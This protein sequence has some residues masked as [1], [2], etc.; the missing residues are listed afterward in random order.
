MGSTLQWRD[1]M[2]ISPSTALLAKCVCS[3]SNFPAHAVY[4]RS[5][6]HSLATD[7][8][9]RRVDNVQPL[10]APMTPINTGRMEAA[11]RDPDANNPLAPVS[12]FGAEFG[13]SSGSTLILLSLSLSLDYSPYCDST[14]LLPNLTGNHLTWLDLTILEV[15][16]IWTYIS[17][18]I[19]DIAACMCCFLYTGFSCHQYLMIFL[20]HFALSISGSLSVL[21]C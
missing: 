10:H 7:V 17:T 19:V 4:M 20:L 3:V 6:D 21:L 8:H 14:L 16:V 13:S 11:K 1:M 18:N 15:S 2:T 9:Q 5:L 12:V